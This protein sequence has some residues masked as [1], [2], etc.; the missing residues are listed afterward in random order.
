MSAQL[1][2]DS[3]ISD[4]RRIRDE[5]V[6]YLTARTDDSEARMRLHQGVI[7]GL[8]RAIDAITKRYNNLH[9]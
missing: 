7:L 1:L 5:Y 2:H 6:Q 8:D 4:L 3:S 9:Q